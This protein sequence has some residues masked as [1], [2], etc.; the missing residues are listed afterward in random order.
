MK[1]NK[2]QKKLYWLYGI[3]VVVIL[4]GIGVIYQLLQCRVRECMLNTLLLP[5]PFYVFISKDFLVE[6]IP[7]YNL[8][9]GCDPLFLYGF[10]VV[11]NILII[12]LI[13]ALIGVVYK[14]AMGR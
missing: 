9:A 11:V 10:S 12:C 5:S 7:A 13:G 2:L 1:K 6:T 4:Y 8:L 14:L 3:N